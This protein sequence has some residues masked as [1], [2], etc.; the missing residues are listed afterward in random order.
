[1]AGVGRKKEAEEQIQIAIQFGHGV[2]HFHHA[3][4]LIASA[5]ALMGNSKAA[6]EW[7][8]KAAEDG[9]PCYPLYNKD[10]NLKNIKNDPAFISFMQ[11]L[12]KQCESYKSGL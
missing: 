7:L 5:Y 1:M 2:S 11:K 9:F 6:M 8:K 10:P 4:Y 12:K 3:E